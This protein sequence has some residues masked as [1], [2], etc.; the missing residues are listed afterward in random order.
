MSSAEKE[1][2]K[3][4]Y[5]LERHLVYVMA[6]KTMKHFEPFISILSW[7]PADSEEIFNN[8]PFY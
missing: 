2:F 8:L 3:W 7:R 1:K 5:L 4:K 6:F